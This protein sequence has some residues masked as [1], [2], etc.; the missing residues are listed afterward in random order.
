VFSLDAGP[1]GPYRVRIAA[2]ASGDTEPSPIEYGA[3]VAGN[4]GEGDAFEDGTF[5]DRFHFEGSAGE[6]V[7]VVLEADFDAYLT[8]GVPGSMPIAEDDDGFGG[9]DSYLE[10]ELPADGSY[11][12]TVTSFLSGS[13]D[14]RLRLGPDL[15]VEPSPDAEVTAALI[16]DEEREGLQYDGERAWHDLLAFSLPSPGADFT[17]MDAAMA[18]ELMGEGA[19]NVHM[20][21]FQD[22]LETAQFMIM[23]IK[24]GAVADRAT[25]EMMT[26]LLQESAAV[27]VLEEEDDWEGSRS[28]FSHFAATDGSEAELRCMAS[29]EERTAGLIVCLLG[30]STDGWSFRELM[31]GLEVR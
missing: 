8:L 19:P 30:S 20:W 2:V 17:L 7:K 11:E 5:L 21:I 26:T 3:D 6:V 9:T 1:D 22:V 27:E 15:D 4:L 12:V 31:G 23:V 24:T 14:Y 29:P 18:E 25:V 16:T 13:G 10:V 28:F